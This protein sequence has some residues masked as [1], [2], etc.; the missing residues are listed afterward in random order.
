MVD[1]KLKANELSIRLICTTICCITKARR[2][3][4]CLR[5]ESNF[6]LSAC[7]NL[8]WF[9]PPRLLLLQVLSS[10]II[11][12]KANIIYYVI[13]S[14]LS[15]SRS[16]TIDWEPFTSKRVTFWHRCKCSALRN[17][18]WDNAVAVPNCLPNASLLS[19]S[20]LYHLNFNLS[21]TLGT[22]FAKVNLALS[23]ALHSLIWPHR[24]QTVLG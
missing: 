2:V 19:A 17:A 9:G 12:A 24:E 20:W 18:Q 22:L 6:S 10:C 21:T 15:A 16:L 5:K 11:D 23:I 13:Q 1:G 3:V 14:V 4:S 7:L 8:S